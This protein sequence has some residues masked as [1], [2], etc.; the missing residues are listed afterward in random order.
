MWMMSLFTCAQ[1]NADIQSLT[2]VSYSSSDQHKDTMNARQKRDHDDTKLI[3]S[4]LSDRSPFTVDL[5]SAFFFANLGPKICQ[6]L[7]E[8]VPK[9][10]NK[11]AKR[12]HICR[13]HFPGRIKHPR[14]YKL[15]LLTKKERQ[16][17]VKVGSL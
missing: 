5:A 16:L 8:K 2:G 6:I 10:S 1:V 13:K 11:F 17:I 3:L 4:Y 15:A 7:P 14:K 12:N 9:F